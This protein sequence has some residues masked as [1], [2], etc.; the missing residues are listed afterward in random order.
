[1]IVGFVWIFVS[2]L[3]AVFRQ[4]IANTMSRGHREF[5]NGE[6]S[7]AEMRSTPSSVLLTALM[8]FITGVLLILQATE[9]IEFSWFSKLSKNM[10]L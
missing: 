2:V 8:I 4:A 1:M 10:V 6:N 7:E 3:L 5:R 9:V